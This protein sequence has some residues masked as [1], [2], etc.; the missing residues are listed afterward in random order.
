MGVFR[1]RPRKGE[2]MSKLVDLSH[3]WNIHTPPWSGYPSAKIWYFQRL[4]DAGVVSQMIETTLHMGTHLDAPMHL[5]G[6]GTSPVKS[7]SEK[8]TS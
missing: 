2:K 3:L 8:E 1:Q 6:R 4:Q 5:G 7:T